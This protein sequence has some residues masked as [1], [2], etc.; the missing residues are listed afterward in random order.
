MDTVESYD[1]EK[2]HWEPLPSMGTQRGRFDVAELHGKLYACG[3]SNGS[4][5]LSSVECFDF[6]EQKWSY[7]ASLRD[8]RSNCGR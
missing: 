1:M 8:V 3:G 4:V 7:V 5:E 6:E 2:N